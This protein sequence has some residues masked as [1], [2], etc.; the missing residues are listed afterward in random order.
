MKLALL[1]LLVA[2]TARG[3]ADAPRM[4]HVAPGY[5]IT[6]PSWVLNE[7]GKEKLDAF[8]Q[9]DT[10]TIAQCKADTTALKAEPALTWKGAALL[11]GIGILL[12]GT[13]V[14]AVKR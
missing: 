11:V 6:R 13:V 10:Q 8:I 4:E 5:V 9:G 3:E 2:G 1:V 7:P 14:L 12:G